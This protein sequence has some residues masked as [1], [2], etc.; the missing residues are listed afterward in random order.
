MERVDT[1]CSTKTTP[2]EGKVGELATASRRVADVGGGS[3]IASEKE[4]LKSLHSFCVSV[5]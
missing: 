3:E 4:L 1:S 5:Y 2:T